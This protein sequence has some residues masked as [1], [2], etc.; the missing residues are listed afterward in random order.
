MLVSWTGAWL[1]LE[2]WRWGLWLA[3]WYDSLALHCLQSSTF[4]MNSDS[5]SLLSD[6]V[7]K[8]GRV[9]QLLPSS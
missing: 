7:S 5:H 2:K 8:L 6:R 3:T 9:R 1:N 4:G